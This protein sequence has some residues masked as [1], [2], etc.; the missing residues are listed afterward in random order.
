MKLNREFYNRDTLVVAQELLGKVLV[1][2]VDGVRTAGKI[3]RSL[4]WANR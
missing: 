2:E 1:H 3:G 4:Y